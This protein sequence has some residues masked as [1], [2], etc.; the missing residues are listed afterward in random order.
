MECVR[1]LPTTPFPGS[2]ASTQPVLSP[3]LT[4][5]RPTA[6]TL[7]GGV[8]QRLVTWWQK[9]G[10]LDP[11]LDR[12]HSAIDRGLPLATWGQEFLTAFR[13]LLD[14]KGERLYAK[15]TLRFQALIAKLSPEQLDGCLLAMA[16]EGCRHG[17]IDPIREC[18]YLV[19]FFKIKEL[20]RYQQ[21]Q[22][23]ACEK[24]FEDL[25]REALVLVENFPLP[26]PE[27]EGHLGQGLRDHAD[28]IRDYI[29]NFFRS[30][31]ETFLKAH[32][33]STEDE[34]PSDRASAMYQLS[35]FYTVAAVPLALGAGI[36]GVAKTLTLVWWVPYAAIAACFLTVYLAICLY[37]KFCPSTQLLGQ[38]SRNLTEEAKQGHLEP[39]LGRQRE[40]SKLIEC[41]GD[42]H[43]R[44]LTPLI[45]GPSGVGKTEIVKGLALEITS[46]RISRLANKQ[47]FLINP[48]DLKEKG[49]HA[50]GI[51]RSRL[52]VLLD[53]LRGREDETIL[54]FDEVHTLV[55][56]GTKIASECD[57][58]EKFKTI[59][60]MG[61][62]RCIAATTDKEYHATIAANAALSR[63]FTKIDIGPLLGDECKD[64]L[65]RFAANEYPEIEVTPEAV[66]TAVRLAGSANAEVA[67]LAKAKELLV[68]AMGR[69][70][71]PQAAAY[72]A[73]DALKEDL[74][75]ARRRVQADVLAGNRAVDAA[76]HLDSLSLL[77]TKVEQ[78]YRECE[79]L[80]K[81]L[82]ELQQSEKQR[83]ALWQRYISLA[84]AVA[85]HAPTSPSH[86]T[87]Y[88]SFFLL[89]HYLL[90]GMADA[91]KT[92]QEKLLSQNIPVRVDEPLVRKVYQERHS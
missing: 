38:L 20:W 57:L 92:Q 77:T 89:K 8:W 83:K 82:S 61:K 72:E 16:A 37:R 27:S 18:L 50:N 33:F 78:A 91:V 15:A 73:L 11:V 86:Q 52:E 66:A 59:L 19:P 88:A 55:D 70:A 17:L 47:L 14:H 46:G 25:Y 39:V 81:N 85:S 79:V 80:Q 29:V 28:S 31:I 62:I 58:G 43:H 41:L 42:Q 5:L 12:L 34:V 45:V 10:P 22:L 65:L 51:Y 9:V 7:S 75:R 54:F 21:H 71:H 84:H 87:L 68:E 90:G 35:N 63:R 3:A 48:S 23:A 44:G 4:S 67:T 69:V 1:V 6:P 60:D 76:A 24:E 53:R 49:T 64:A 26:H 56:D 13:T 2:C 40:V 30:T 32:D 74:E 36:M